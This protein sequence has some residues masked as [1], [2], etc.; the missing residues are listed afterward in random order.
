MESQDNQQILLEIIQRAKEEDYTEFKPI[1]SWNEYSAIS[2]YF[3][4]T[5]LIIKTLNTT[6]KNLMKAYC[7]DIIVGTADFDILLAYLE[8]NKYLAFYKKELNTISCMLGEYEDY[9][10]NGHFWH[11]YLGGERDD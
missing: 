2:R 9:L 11:S 5:K 10:W 1:S 3:W 8:V 4:S 7:K 6:A